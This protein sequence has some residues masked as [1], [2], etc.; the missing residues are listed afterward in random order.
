MNYLEFST[1]EICLF[2]PFSYLVIYMYQQRLMDACVCLCSVM[3]DSLRP[4]WTLQPSRLLCPWD[5]PG[6]N[7][8]V[9]CHDLLQGI[10]PAQGLNQ[11]HL[12]WQVDSLP[13]CHLGNP[14]LWI[15]ILYFGLL[16]NTTL[17]CCSHCSSF[18]HWGLSW[19]ARVCVYLF[20]ATIRCSSLILCISCPVL[21]STSSPRDSR[22]F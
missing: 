11:H 6:K 13:L 12:H 2:S 20:S 3:S 9:G 15:F 22:F 19:L 4:A 1:R 16:Y 18:G 5:S 10:F 21:E 17:F 8:G 14:G 7:T